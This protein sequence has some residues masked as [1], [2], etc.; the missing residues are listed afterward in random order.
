MEKEFND[1]IHKLFG[2]KS[3]EDLKKG[4]RKAQLPSS[5]SWNEL[6]FGTPSGKYEFSSDLAADYGHT[7]LPEYKAPRK[8]YD[9]FRVLTPHTQFGLHSQFNNL[10]YM[11]DFNPEPYVYINPKAAAKKGI[12]DGE[13]VKLTNKTGSVTVKARITDIIAEDVL[14]LYEAWFGGKTDFNVQELVDDAEADMGT[15]KTGA[16]GVAIHDQF[17]EI[18]KA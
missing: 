2:I 3:W 9:K 12:K 15:F 4:P 11:R 6:K 18:A 17:A 1:G 7:K 8:A 14:V 5:A 13:T 10:D 16:P